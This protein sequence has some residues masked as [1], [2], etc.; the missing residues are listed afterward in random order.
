MK[1]KEDLKTRI[2]NLYLFLR[3]GQT[4][5]PEHYKLIK[6]CVKKG[7]TAI[8]IGAYRGDYIALFHSLEMK[9]HAF[10]PTFNFKTIR[11]RFLLCKGLIIYKMAVSAKYRSLTFNIYEDDSA[12]SYVDVPSAGKLIAKESV[13]CIR[14]DEYHLKPSFIKIDVNGMELDVLISAKQTIQKHKPFILIAYNPQLLSL[15]GATKEQILKFMFE[16]DYAFKEIYSD[17]ILTDLFFL[18]RKKL[19]MFGRPE[20]EEVEAYYKNQLKER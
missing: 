18:P 1:T 7:N 16:F 5:N 20:E 15:T 8:D 13:F 11:N 14:L 10:E 2:R 6:R 17:G 4:L 3:Y 9:V 19:S 12:A